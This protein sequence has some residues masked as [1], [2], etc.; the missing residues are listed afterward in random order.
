MTSNIRLRRRGR[1]RAQKTIDLIDAAVR[2]LEEIQPATVRAVC[3]RLFIEKLIPSREK[4]NTNRISRL[5]TQA[6]EDGDLDWD[7]VV[8]ETREAERIS[9]WQDVAEF[10]E[11][12]KRSYRRNYWAAQPDWIE[13]WS[14]KG[15]VRGTLA[16]ILNHYGIT[17]RVMHG[18]GSATAVHAAAEETEDSDKMLTVLYVGDWDPSGMHMSEI[19]LPERL[20]RYGGN[21][22]IVRCAIDVTDTAPV[23][24]V[25]WF[26][27]SDKTKDPR[28]KWFIENYG[29][30]CWELDA[31]SPVI[32]RNRIHVQIQSR[33]DMEA[34][35]HSIKI[36]AAERES[37][38]KVFS[39]FREVFLGKPRNTRPR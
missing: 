13:V 34:W 36:E 30:R 2:I 24:G 11:T 9:S 10:G 6:R 8:D 23:A 7:W 18:H 31:L 32:L 12:V 3:Y 39:S 4:T 17:F 20:D 35:E 15:T 1:G 37:M 22:D 21:I 33:L 16:P 25:P 26:P 14:E 38:N 19:D 28:H 27:A 5:L 29:T